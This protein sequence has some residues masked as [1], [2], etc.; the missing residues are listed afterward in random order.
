MTQPQIISNYKATANK[1]LSK[2]K[3]LLGGK[4]KFEVAE[5]LQ[6]N[7][8]DLLAYLSGS[9]IEI[10]ALH[11][12]VDAKHL[13]VK[14]VDRMKNDELFIQY[15]ELKG[16]PLVDVHIVDDAETLSTL[17][18]NSEDFV[19]ANHVIEHMVSPIKALLTWQKVL[20]KGGKL[21][22]AVPDKNYTFDKG[23]EYTDFS[24]ILEDFNNPSEERDY[25]HFE[26]FALHASCRTFKVRP[27]EEYKELAKELWDRQY[28]IHYH[29]WDYNT[30]N[31]FLD[32][33]AENISDWKMKIIAKMPTKGEEFI[34]VLEKE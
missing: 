2:F 29:V 12:P 3:R 18:P 16:L 15:P 31:I 1:T 11:R 10:G 28:S 25:I 22:L 17:S 14:Y 8:N 20:K 13:K 23:R 33:L 6:L 24:H 4:T 19:I 34:Y 9:G 21:F 27:E 26:E 30:F 7:R 32:N 5:E